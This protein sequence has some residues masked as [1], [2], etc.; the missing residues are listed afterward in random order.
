[1]SDLLL[2]DHQIPSDFAVFQRFIRAEDMQTVIAVLESHNI[3]VRTSDVSSGEWRD[4]VITGAP[5]QP[6]FWIEIPSG[7]FEKAN[8]MLQEAAEQNISDADLNA[9][10]FAEYDR[11]EL[12]EV[13]LEETE[14]SPDA[15][16]VARK[17][18]LRKGHDVDLER[19]RARSRE[20]VSRAI[21]AR[22]GTRWV[23]ALFTLYGGFAAMAIWM[24][25]IMVSIGVLV[26]YVTGSQRDPKGNMHPTY[27]ESTRTI[28]RVA[29]GVVALCL[30]FGLTNLFYLKWISFPPI[31]VWYWL[32]F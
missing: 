19:L 8:F 11:P 26:Y 1:M 18:L 17:L 30:V 3:P 10:P 6:K 27:D 7:K 4:A 23:L 31:D 16:V 28:G 14:W 2:D 32:W 24:V 22:S 5:L 13:L 29:L 12:E 21:Q 20:R 25:S 15:V 9:H